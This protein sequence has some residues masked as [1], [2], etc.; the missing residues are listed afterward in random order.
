MAH[1]RKWDSEK[2]LLEE[3][4]AGQAEVGKQN[5][6][7]EEEGQNKKKNRRRSSFIPTYAHL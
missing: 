2:E 3:I 6:L 7:V 5:P 4:L 1:G